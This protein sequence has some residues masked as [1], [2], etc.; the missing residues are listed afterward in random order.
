MGENLKITD[1]I[2][3]KRQTYFKNL[4][5]KDA[6]DICLLLFDLKRIFNSPID[7]AIAKYLQEMENPSPFW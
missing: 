3:P 6:N 1:S 5:Y 7:K 2:N 4:N